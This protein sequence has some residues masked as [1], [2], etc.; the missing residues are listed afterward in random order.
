MRLLITKYDS[1]CKRCN[2]EVEKGKE[3]YYEKSMGIFCIDCKPKDVEEIRYYRQ[4]KIDKKK[5]RLNNRANRLEKEANSKMEEMDSYRGD[6]AFHTQPGHIPQRARIIKKYDKGLEMLSEA[7]E[8]KEKAN[9][10]DSARVK[11]DAARR[12]EAKRKR[13]DELISIGSKVNDF[14]FGI[15]EVKKVNKKTYTIKW[16]SGG[17]YT[18]DKIFVKPLINK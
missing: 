8:L 16:N 2:K 6:T 17:T 1:Y 14:A 15:G 18:R 4:L 5:E 12:D 13:N 11:G 7:N 10:M 3:V 9:Y